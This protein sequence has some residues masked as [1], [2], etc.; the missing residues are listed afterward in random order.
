MILTSKSKPELATQADYESGLAYMYLWQ[1]LNLDALP[2]PLQDPIKLGFAQYAYTRKRKNREREYFHGA[3]S[4]IIGTLG[5]IERCFNV[6]RGTLQG[7]II[8]LKVDKWD[9]VLA[10][11]QYVHNNAANYDQ[12]VF[13]MV[14]NDYPTLQ[15]AWCNKD[16]G[17]KT[18]WYAASEK[19]MVARFRNCWRKT[20]QSI[21]RAIVD[22]KRRRGEHGVPERGTPQGGAMAGAS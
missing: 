20:N 22:A 1:L 11:E 3:Q 17:G 19:T 13:N 6:P 8:A 16:N 15:R 7:R 12:K 21:G 18:E 14:M 10:S 5:D 2:E 9:D 4:R